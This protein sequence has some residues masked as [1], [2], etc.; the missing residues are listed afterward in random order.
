MYRYCLDLQLNTSPSIGLTT[1]IPICTYCTY[2]YVL[3]YMILWKHF[4]GLDLAHC[5]LV[6]DWLA[7]YHALS[8]VLMKRAGDTEKWAGSNRW[9]LPPY[10]YPTA[11]HEERENDPEY[12][13]GERETLCEKAKVT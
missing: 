4:S 9:A 10:A 3:P 7:R 11:L 8:H 6:M 12:Q 13:A 2:Y 5:S 1:D